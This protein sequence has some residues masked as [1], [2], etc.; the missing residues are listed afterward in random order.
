MATHATAVLGSAVDRG[1]EEIE[2]LLKRRRPGLPLVARVLGPNVF[3]IGR[4][5]RQAQ[6][7][8]T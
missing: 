4:T 3:G 7:N 1:V 6:M 8:S 5:R 2:T